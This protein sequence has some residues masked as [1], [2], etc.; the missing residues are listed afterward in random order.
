MSSIVVSGDTSGSI[1]LSAPAVAGSSVL[2]LPAVTDTLAGIAA[3]QTLT[4]KTL[5]SPVLTTPALGTPSALVL[6]NATGLPRAALPTGSVLQV[7]NTVTASIVSG[8]NV[9]VPAFFFQVAFTPLFTSSRVLIM[10][11]MGGIDT[12]GAGRLAVTIKQNTTSG[13]TTGSQ[14]FQMQCAQD[15]SGTSGISCLSGSFIYPTT[16]FTAGTTY[17]IKAIVEKQDTSTSW[18]V[19]QYSNDSSITVMEISA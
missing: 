4:N 2:T 5:T 9:N 8:T 13:G 3:T 18:A 16:T 12:G 11:N 7:V 15:S 14:A 17:Y 6:T 19:S 1:T 10:A